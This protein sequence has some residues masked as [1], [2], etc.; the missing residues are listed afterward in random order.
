MAVNPGNQTGG[1]SIHNTITGQ[2]IANSPAA[3]IWA[4]RNRASLDNNA[5]NRALIE[6]GRILLEG[7]QKEVAKKVGITFGVVFIAALIFKFL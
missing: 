1:G 4:Y 5:E 6:K 2:S 3:A 7:E